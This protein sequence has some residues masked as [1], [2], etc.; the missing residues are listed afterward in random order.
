MQ[1]FVETMKR[2]GAWNEEAAEKARLA[3]MRAIGLWAWRRAGPA[4][5]GRVGLDYQQIEAAHSTKQGIQVMR[6]LGGTPCA[7][8]T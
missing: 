7:S 3:K 8:F 2:E 5:C 4:R 1:T 6:T